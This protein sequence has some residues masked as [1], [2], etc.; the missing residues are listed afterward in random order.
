M[1][2]IPLTDLPIKTYEPTDGQGMCIAM[3][4]RCPIFFRGKTPMQAAAA[5]EKWRQEE[6]AKLDR[7]KAKREA[8][9]NKGRVSE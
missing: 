7:A 1:P 8:R 3:I 2:K 4:E 5:A 6:V 9:R